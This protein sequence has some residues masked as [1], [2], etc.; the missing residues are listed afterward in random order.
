MPGIS[1]QSN[2]SR[3]S[4]ETPPARNGLYCLAKLPAYGR[5]YLF[6]PPLTAVF[7]FP[8]TSTAKARRGA[9]LCQFGRLSILS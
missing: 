2:Q 3:K 4:V 5:M 8:N 9:Q 1:A 6:T 7:P